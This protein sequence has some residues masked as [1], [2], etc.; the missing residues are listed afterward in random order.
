MI[1]VL[2]FDWNGTIINDT[3]H[4]YATAVNIILK[5]SKKEFCCQRL[6]FSN[7]RKEFNLPYE[8]FYKEF[9]IVLTP[10]I[11]KEF[12]R[13]YNKLGPP[14][15]FQ[16]FK[17]ACAKINKIGIKTMIITAT[18]N[19]KSLLEIIEKEKLK[20]LLY[21]IFWKIDDKAE[22]LKRAANFY[23]ASPEEFLYIGDM[24]YDIK[25]SKEAGVK[26]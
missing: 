17:K 22:A 23:K 3:A 8:N 24:I 13:F 7:F 16:D 5:Y 1:K 26:C 9:G 20:G 2:A 11:Y 15:L 25:S 6:K 18:S 10:K 19:K 4:V 14:P 21:P 12:H